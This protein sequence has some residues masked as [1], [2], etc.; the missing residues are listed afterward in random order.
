MLDAG[1]RYYPPDFITD[2]VLFAGNGSVSNVMLVA[3]GNAF[4]L[5]YSSPVGNWTDAKL[6]GRGNRILLGVEGKEMEFLTKVGSMAKAL[7]GGGSLLRRR[8]RSLEG[9]DSRDG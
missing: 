3:A 6:I 2:S 1:R 7:F 5:N 8:C 9:E 4:A